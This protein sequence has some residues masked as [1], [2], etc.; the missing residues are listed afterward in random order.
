MLFQDPPD[1]TRLR[2]IE[3]IGPI[4]READTGWNHFC[5]PDGNVYEIMSRGG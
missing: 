3:F 5:G 2:G 1:H 4:Q